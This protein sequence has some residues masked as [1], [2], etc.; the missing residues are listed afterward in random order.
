MTK[1]KRQLQELF[2]LVRFGIVGVV[3][4]LV[5]MAVAA[6]LVHSETANVYL[7]NLVAYLT[8]FIVAFSGHFFWTFNNGGPL[9]Q[10]IWR[11]FVISASAF[12]V[13]NL[14]LLTL[15]QSGLVSK[16]SSVIVAAAIV[17]VLSFFASRFWGFRTQ[18]KTIKTIMPSERHNR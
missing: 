9:G 18:P 10:A 11:Y 17:P 3:A 8:A 2:M 12:G 7:A 14:V 5:H 4:T 16:V 6:F 1:W 13:N 15:V